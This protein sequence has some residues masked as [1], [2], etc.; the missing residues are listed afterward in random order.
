VR[1]RY[2]P[3]DRSVATGVQPLGG[4]SQPVHTAT[5][6][7][8]PIY[9]QV[10]AVPPWV[11]CGLSAGEG[12]WGNA[13]GMFEVVP[14]R[15]SPTW[16]VTDRRDFC[17]PFKLIKNLFTST[18]LRCGSLCN[19]QPV[20]GGPLPCVLTGSRASASRFRTLCM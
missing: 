1:I 17:V 9:P 8:Y 4:S 5:G 10:G 3:C 14:G 7:R 13:L 12:G 6:D 11:V 20:R 18:A 2:L 19:F 15:P 16:G